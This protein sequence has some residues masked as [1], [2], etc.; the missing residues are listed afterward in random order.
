MKKPFYQQI[1]EQYQLG[2]ASHITHIDNLEKIIAD[3]LLSHNLMSGKKYFDLSD[4]NIQLGRENK[5][6]LDTGKTLHDYVPLYF[7]WKSPM[8]MRHQDKNEQI[9]YLRYSLDILKTSGAVISNGNARSNDTRFYNFKEIKDLSNLNAQAINSVKW[10]GEPEKKRQKQA[11]ILIPD[12]IPFS[13]VFEIIC[14]SESV[15]NRVMDILEKS[16]ISTKVKV[17][18]GWYYVPQKRS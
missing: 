10:V 12:Q 5:I 9:I 11:E 18:S 3:G 2:P 15:Q 6:I 16:G 13:Q 14:Y 1:K 17:N 7:G 8:L 4:P